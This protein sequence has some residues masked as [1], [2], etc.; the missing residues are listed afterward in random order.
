MHQ[1]TSEPS[2]SQEAMKGLLLGL[3]LAAMATFWWVWTTLHF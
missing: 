1:A 3:A 2:G